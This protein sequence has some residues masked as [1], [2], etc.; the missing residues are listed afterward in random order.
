MTVRTGS[1]HRLRFVLAAT[2]ACDKEVAL[3]R[4]LPTAMSIRL[5]QVSNEESLR[6]TLGKDR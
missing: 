6:R 2:G 4:E 3:G 1:N 5:K